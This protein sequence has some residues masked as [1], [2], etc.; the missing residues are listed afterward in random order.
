ML[1][2]V[3]VKKSRPSICSW[4]LQFRH[5]SLLHLSSWSNKIYLSSFFVSKS[6]LV[7]RIKY[8]AILRSAIQYYSNK[9]AIISVERIWLSLLW[10]IPSKAC[11]RKIKLEVIHE[12]LEPSNYKLLQANLNHTYLQNRSI[13]RVELWCSKKWS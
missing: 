10:N 3:W 13:W 11:Q 5:T 4:F 2:I 1:F 9:R 8:F 12:P 7:G 6:S